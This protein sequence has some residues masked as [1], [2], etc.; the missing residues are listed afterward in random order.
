MSKEN[1]ELCSINIVDREKVELVK[2]GLPENYKLTDI[3]EVFKV[4]AVPTRL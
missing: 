2:N 1:S 4:L 3:A